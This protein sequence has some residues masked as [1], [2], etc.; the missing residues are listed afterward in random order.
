MIVQGFI[1]ESIN[2]FKISTVQ[3]ANKILERILSGEPKLI[4]FHFLKPPSNV[5]PE[6]IPKNVGLVADQED[7]KG[8]N[9]FL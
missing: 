7:G 5:S 1:L 2:T 8:N 9:I 4:V 3:D 6:P